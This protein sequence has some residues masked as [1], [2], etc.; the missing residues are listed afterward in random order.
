[1]NVNEMKTAWQ[2]WTS[3]PG[4][5][6]LDAACSKQY[7]YRGKQ[8][9]HPSTYAFAR[10]DC[11]PADDLS[12]EMQ[13]EWPPSQGAFYRGLLQDAMSAAIVDAL[14]GVASP[15]TGCALKCVEIKWDEVCS[16]PMSFYLATHAAMSALRDEEK[17]SFIQ[18]TKT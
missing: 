8:H 6:R 16:S 3:R 14:V 18:K 11:T 15:R 2:R 7:E 5:M 10:F 1:M 4:G 17:W 13:A 12:F 9:G